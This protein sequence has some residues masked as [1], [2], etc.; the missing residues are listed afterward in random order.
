MFGGGFLL[1]SFLKPKG[2][3]KSIMQNNANATKSSF[4]GKKEITKNDKEMAK[5][6]IVAYQQ[7]VINGEDSITLSELNAECMREYG[8]KCSQKKDG[9]FVVSDKY[10]REILSV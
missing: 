4:N 10:G 8:M 6:V 3:L 9:T 1:F 2:S 7:A 5:I